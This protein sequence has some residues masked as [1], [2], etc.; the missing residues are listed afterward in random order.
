MYLG[1]IGTGEEITFTVIVSKNLADSF[2][3]WFQM[4]WD[5]CTK[6]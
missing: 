1:K 6:P 4:M 3:T 2:R 5:A